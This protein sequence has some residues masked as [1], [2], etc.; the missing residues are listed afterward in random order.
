M[1]IQETKPQMTV[2]QIANLRSF[3]KK[4]GV[5]KDKL[6]PA[7]IKTQQVIVETHPVVE[8][9]QQPIVAKSAIELKQTFKNLETYFFYNDEESGSL[10]VDLVTFREKG[11]ETRYLSF[12]LS[13]YDLN[14]DPPMPL[15]ST[16]S[17]SRKEDFEKMKKFFAQLNWED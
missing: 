14:Q 1:E 3:G 6:S 15:Q 7:Q 10:E 17:I 13:G 8:K 5:S 12:S 11:E 4:N 9:T 2:E 16:L